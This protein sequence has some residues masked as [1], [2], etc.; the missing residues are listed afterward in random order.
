MKLGISTACFY[1]QD[2]LES[3]TQAQALEP[4]CLEIFLN[5]FRELEPD[6][7]ARLKAQL[8]KGGIPL[9]SIHPF[10]SAMEPFFFFSEYG[11]RY[12][13][14][15]RVY[16]R[17]FEVCRE[18]GARIL[19]FHG[20]VKVKLLPPEEHARRFCRLVAEAEQYGI[21][22]AQENVD[23]CQCGSPAQVRALRECADRPIRF[24]LDLKQARR[25]GESIPEMI[26]A[27]GPENICH[28]HLS[29]AR[30]GEVC[31]APG[32]GE[33]DLP[34]LLRDLRR[35]GFD[36]DGV[37]ELYRGNYKEAAQLEQACRL[38]NAAAGNKK[39]E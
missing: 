12:E 13:D 8:Q 25:A 19:V 9:R 26:D 37:I 16:R 18:L 32:E 39:E 31:L 29:D 24:V 14:G 27:M 3:L 33:E 36:G 35:R 30:G 11:P 28:L 6:Y 10:T 20:N 4:P 7:V 15:L 34:A 17:Y 21:V 23:R 2:T 38:L 1:P 5:T 22:L